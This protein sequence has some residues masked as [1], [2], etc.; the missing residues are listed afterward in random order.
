MVEV[1]AFDAKTWTYIQQNFK[2]FDK[3]GTDT[4]HVSDIANALRMCGFNPKEEDLESLQAQMEMDGDRVSWEKFRECVD[5]AMKNYH[6]AEECLNAFRAFDPDGRGTISQ[7]DLRFI[8]TTM[9]DKLDRAE[10]NELMEQVLADDTLKDENFPPN[11]DYKNLVEMWQPP[12]FK[13][14]PD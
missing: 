3:D 10:I 5:D 4:I 11:I 7:N 12:I 6:T 1:D 2:L 13:L 9:G 14:V 8:L